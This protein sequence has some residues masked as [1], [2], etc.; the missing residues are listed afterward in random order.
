LK[1]RFLL[2]NGQHCTEILRGRA[3]LLRGKRGIDIRGPALAVGGFRWHQ[4]HYFSL[5]FGRRTWRRFV[6]ALAGAT[7]QYQQCGEADQ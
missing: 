3:D 4:P 6:V 2:G 1:G 5:H 7:G